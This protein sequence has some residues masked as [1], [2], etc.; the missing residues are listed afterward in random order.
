[1][2]RVWPDLVCLVVRAFLVAATGWGRVVWFAIV[3]LGERVEHEKRIT[4][5]QLSAPVIG[6]QADLEDAARGAAARELCGRLCLRAY[7]AVGGRRR[8]PY[9]LSGLTSA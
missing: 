6:A 7:A 9:H 4:I 8:T 3:Q 2:V 1:M 5:F